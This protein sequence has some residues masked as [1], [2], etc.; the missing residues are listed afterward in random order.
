MQTL[1]RNSRAALIPGSVAVVGATDREGA[2]G[3]A[4]WQNLLE[5]KFSGSLFAV[6]PKH[7]RIGKEV[8]YPQLAALPQ[9]VDLVIIT[10]MAATTPDTISEAAKAGA[11]GILILTP[12]FAR[13][14]ES[15]AELEQK[16]LNVARRHRVRLFGPN[17]MGFMR[18]SLGLNASV[19]RT[20]AR[21]GNIGLIS[22]SGALTASLLDYARGSGFGFSS[23]LTL[24]A[25]LD[26]GFADLID[27]LALDGQTRSI[28]VYVESVRQPRRF[29]S[30]L[31]AAASIKPVIVLKAGRHAQD[32]PSSIGHLGALRG[33]DAVFEAALGRTGAMR[34][35]KYAQLFSA[36]EALLA[37]VFP[38]G[39]R[40][41]VLGNGKA[42]GV[43]A[44]DVVAENGLAL[45]DLSADTLQKLRDLRR[46][47]GKRMHFMPARGQTDVF[48]VGL[49]NPVDLGT[50]ID[51]AS[52][53][54]ALTIVLADPGADGVL[55]LAVPTLSAGAGELAKALLPVVEGSRKPVVSSWLGESE[56][57]LGRSIMRQAG[58]VAMRSPE[59][60]VEA[61]AYLARYIRLREL[62]LQL[63]APMRPDPD[64]DRPFAASH[65]RGLLARAQREGSQALPAE[66][67]QTL[68]DACGIPVVPTRLARTPEDALRIAKSLGYPVAL[69]VRATGVWHKSDVGGVRLNL[70]ND[71]EVLASFADIHSNLRTQAPE[72]EFVGVLIQKMV[73]RRS[74]RELTIGLSRDPFFGPV[75]RFGMG[76]IAVDIISDA[77]LAMPPLNRVLAQDLI[78]RTRV[79]AMLKHFRGMPPVNEAALVDTLLRVSELACEFPCITELDINP[80]VVDEAGV[81]V[82]D[83]RVS[84]DD[85]PL[86]PDPVYSHLAIHPY[87]RYLER[88]LPLHDGSTVLLRPVRPEDAEAQKRFVARL[89]DLTLYRRFHAPIR[90]LSPERLVRFTQIDYDR[91]MAFVAIDID[92]EDGSEEIRAFGQY[93]RVVDGDDAEF[94]IAV[95]DAWQ[96]RGLGFAMMEAIESCARDRHVSRINGFV[97]A[98]NDAMRAM[99]VARGYHLER[100]PDDPGVVNFTLVL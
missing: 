68:L 58:R 84:I 94:G 50:C 34:I 55:A 9:K 83:V 54:Q 47:A 36:S 17:T 37:G 56:V 85:G 11:A 31:R 22:E 73:V 100:D 45:A 42:P 48:D 10:T 77:A 93:N 21:A 72:S 62:R 99:M 69:K 19:I 71:E 41:A 7:S 24:G 95:E 82:L 40:L 67:A 30:S 80:I 98:D 61:F 86:A 51:A 75:I 39:P 3:R 91:E 88:V 92:E 6:N 70:R 57:S 28:V 96:G 33:N 2:L 8:C 89:S 43:L 4:V 76:G 49:N 46:L 20:P 25:G 64:P 44:A 26:V 38:A 90:E 16:C 23:V 59:Q 87:P 1:S 60:G 63:P 66:V 52:Y 79:A 53:A 12:A 14:R 5:G 81:V 35:F 65:I 15:S 29:L 78:S 13:S 32:A 18:P 27:F 97:L 74:G